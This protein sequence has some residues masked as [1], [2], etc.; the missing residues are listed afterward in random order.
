MVQS[1]QRK[2]QTW[3]G[4]LMCACLSGGKGGL[5][6]LDRLGEWNEGIYR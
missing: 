4:L 1:K 2:G 3:A 6:C 5:E